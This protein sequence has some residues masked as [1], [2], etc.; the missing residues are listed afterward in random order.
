MTDAAPQETAGVTGAAPST[1]AHRPLRRAGLWLLAV[2]VLALGLVGTSP[3][4]MPSI[5][6]WLP[7]ASTASDTS[8]A[9]TTRLSAIERRLDALQALNDRLGILERRPA[10]DSSA[11]IASLDDRLQQLTARLD[12]IDGQIS[13]LIKDQTLR[14]DSAQRVLIVALAELGNALSTSA[15]FAAQLASVEALGQ[16]RP[17]WAMALRPL[18]DTAKSGIPSTAALAHRF[19]DDIAPA[20]LRADAASPSAQAGLG[21]AV[22]SKLRSLVII[23]RTDGAGVAA[24][25]AEAAVAAAEAALAKGDLAGA[26]EALSNLSGTAAAAAAPWLRQARQ[27]LEAEQTLAK[28]TQELSSDLAAGASGG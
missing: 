26:A 9:L 20:I 25:S 11:A 28:L 24:G 8:Q 13:Q 6:P 1:K 15:P 21:E 5:Q 7:A 3:Y 27:R 16:R 19:S 23:R 18:E 4:W 10:P 14:G 12:R 2:L 17:G 22:L